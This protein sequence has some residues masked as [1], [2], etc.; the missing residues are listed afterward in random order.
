MI[1]SI[2]VA[3][4]VLGAVSRIYLGAHWFT[5]VIGGFIVGVLFVMFTGSLYLR[6]KNKST[7]IQ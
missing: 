3:M 6:S 2:C 4:I 7:D 1:S 5:D